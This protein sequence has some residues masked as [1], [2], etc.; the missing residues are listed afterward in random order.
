VLVLPG[1]DL[2]VSMNKAMTLHSTK[3]CYCHKVSL[4]EYRHDIIL[5]AFGVLNRKGIDFQLLLATENN[6]P[7]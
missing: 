2:D 3:D 7:F 5:K 6:F 4:P 1:I